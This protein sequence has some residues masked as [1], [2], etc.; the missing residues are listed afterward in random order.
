MW[1]GRSLTPSGLVVVIPFA[2]TV[3]WLTILNTFT[4]L[5]YGFQLPLEQ[6]YSLHIFYIYTLHCS[7]LKACHNLPIR[8]SS[9]S[10]IW[11]FMACLL[12][13]SCNGS[14]VLLCVQQV[15]ASAEWGE[16][17][18]VSVDSTSSHNNVVFLCCRSRGS[19][20]CT[21]CCCMSFRTLRIVAHSLASISTLSC[22]AF[23]VQ[24]SLG[25]LDNNLV[26]V[27]VWAVISIEVSGRTDLTSMDR[28]L[29]ATRGFQCKWERGC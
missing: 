8:Q 28:W 19:G 4:C 15:V 13:L 23:V 17:L 9:P 16:L 2:I 20:Q 18:F 25:E 26:A 1:C 11:M 3:K 7:T 27:A 10:V 14:L 12:L 6:E 22:E 29:A 24:K 21:C 5:V